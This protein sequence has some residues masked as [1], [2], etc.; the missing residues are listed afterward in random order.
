MYVSGTIKHV[1]SVISKYYHNTPRYSNLYMCEVRVL[2]EVGELN[3][4]E[5]VLLHSLH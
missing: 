3:F 2:V 1:A 5:P 4:W